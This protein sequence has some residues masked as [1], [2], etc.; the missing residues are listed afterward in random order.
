[1]KES[2]PSK[3]LFFVLVLFYRQALVTSLNTRD[4]PLKMRILTCDKPLSAG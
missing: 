3:S 4:A 2:A 1:M